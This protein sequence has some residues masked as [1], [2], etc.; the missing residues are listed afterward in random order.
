MRHCDSVRSVDLHH[1]VLYMSILYIEVHD[2]CVRGFG[3]Y[4]T[5]DIFYMY[6]LLRCFGMRATRA[7]KML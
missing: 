2:L 4:D 7:D 1:G 3:L 5:K 6:H